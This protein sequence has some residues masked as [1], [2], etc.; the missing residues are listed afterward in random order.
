[1]S[2]EQF[3]TLVK[4]LE[5]V[6]K[7]QPL[8]YKVRVLGMALLGYLYLMAILVSILGVGAG[9]IWLALG[10]DGESSG[11]RSGVLGKILI[12]LGGLA[13][14]VLRAMWV[15]VPPPEGIPLQ[16]QAFPE[17]FRILDTMRRHLKGPKIHAVLLTDVFNASVSQNPRLGIF[18]WP[19]NF[20]VLGLPLLQS[21]SSQQLEAILAHEYGHLSGAHGKFSAWIYRIRMTWYQLMEA[22]D[23][24]ERW[25]RGIFQKFFDWYAPYFGAYSFV[26]ARSNEYEAD[27]CSAD[28]TSPKLAADALTAIYLK[29]ETLHKN[30]WPS[31]YGKADHMPAPPP[32]MY[33]E[34]GKFLR[35]G[36]PG[37]KLSDILERVMAEET[38][39]ADTH[40][41]LKE[42]LTALEQEARI[43]EPLGA[44]AAE[45]LLGSQ[46]ER[47]VHH[48]SQEWVGQVEKG[49]RERHECVRSSM[50]RLEELEAR[51][52]QGDFTDEEAYELAKLSEEFRTRGEALDRYQAVLTLNDTHVSAQFA[53][54]RLLL[55]QDNE[56]GIN[57]IERALELDPEATLE[58]CREVYR[59]LK[60]QGRTEEAERY[61]QRFDERADFEQRVE[62]ERDE[63]SLDD[64]YVAHELSHEAVTA[65]VD[66]L[67]GYKAIARAYLV[68]KH[69]V[70]SEKPLY[71][72]GVKGTW[73]WYWISKD[74]ENCSNL[75]KR[76]VDD[77]S[78]PGEVIFLVLDEQNPK[79]MKTFSAIPEALIYERGKKENI[80]WENK[81][82]VQE[83]K[84]S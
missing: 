43:P 3:D 23:Q 45:V 50:E 16:R 49:W 53:L 18:G 37:A 71:V 34:M 54:G 83:P 22:F 76:L 21:V 60:R 7:K 1:M 28:L 47:L 75:V 77:I 48:L 80:I 58:G 30:F 6:A 10:W 55:D 70:L 64:T 9:A 17:L 19:K 56:G 52:G 67:K 41:A 84:L 36:G 26:L 69:T 59:F 15:R 38:G 51:H 32:L 29:G 74:G 13:F 57:Q 31:V 35:E 12:A 46:H 66:Q 78:F 8:Q 40:P 61:K 24:E 39:S 20:L 79:F 5:G 4:K 65:L 68:R 42:R 73:Y 62:A 25:G 2:N 11:V 82:A 27:R 33:V 72:L 81:N 44:T 14:V 63:L